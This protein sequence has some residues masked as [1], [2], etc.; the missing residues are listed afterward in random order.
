MKENKT[1]MTMGPEVDP[2]P[3]P[4]PGGKEA[5]KYYKSIYQPIEPDRRLPS[6]EEDGWAFLDVP[7]SATEILYAGPLPTRASI[8]GLIPGDLVK[9]VFLHAEEGG[10]RMWV[11]IEQRE[12][13]LFKGTLSNN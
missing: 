10:E 8:D 7:L 4:I 12:E 5:M 2:K 3:T 9:L 11:R 13:G 6:M 1:K